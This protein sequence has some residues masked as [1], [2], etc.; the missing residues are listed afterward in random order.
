MGSNLEENVKIRKCIR[1][2][3]KYNLEKMDLYLLSFSG[4]KK[5]VMQLYDK[6]VEE[7]LVNYADENNPLEGQL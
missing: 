2:C 7:G 3:F 1:D 5:R 4:S 6:S